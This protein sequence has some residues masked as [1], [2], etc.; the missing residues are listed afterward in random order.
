MRAARNCLPV[1]MLDMDQPLFIWRRKANCRAAGVSGS[2]AAVV[3]TFAAKAIAAAFA[4]SAH[5]FGRSEGSLDRILVCAAIGGQSRLEQFPGAA[6]PRWRR[7]SPMLTPGQ[8]RH[9][10]H[11][12]TQKQMLQTRM[13]A[14]PDRR[15]RQHEQLK[16]RR[17]LRPMLPKHRNASPRWRRQSPMLTPG[18]PRHNWH[19]RNSKRPEH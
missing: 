3:A 10:W 2:V 19:L 13:H 17:R 18:Q 4:A 5:A 11:L 8:L 14:P 16:G 7:Q 9:N 6:S 15:W 1:R 12:S